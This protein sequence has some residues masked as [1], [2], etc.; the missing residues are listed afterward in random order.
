M[1]LLLMRCLSRE[2]IVLKLSSTKDSK[3]LLKFLFLSCLPA[4][5]EE[6]SVLSGS[7]YDNKRISFSYFYAHHRQHRGALDIFST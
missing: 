6:K 2:T 5:H 7:D 4:T 1:V 3:Y